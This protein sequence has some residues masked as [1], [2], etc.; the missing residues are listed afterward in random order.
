MLEN[1]KLENGKYLNKFYGKFQPHLTIISDEILDSNDIYFGGTSFTF[2]IEDFG[3]FESFGFYYKDKNGVDFFELYSEE[4][5]THV[6]YK[7]IISNC[8][9]DK[10]VIKKEY[11]EKYKC[12][13][14]HTE[15]IMKNNTGSEFFI[16]PI[17]GLGII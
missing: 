15:R 5:P 3:V 9:K 1:I 14:H 4:P 11:L 16:F 8:N 10:E 12:C 13:F 7:V 17:E 6:L 2:L